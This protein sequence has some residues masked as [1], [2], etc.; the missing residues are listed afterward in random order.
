MI[1]QVVASKP[2]GHG[3]VD[4]DVGTTLIRSFTSLLLRASSAMFPPTR[5]ENHIATS[6]RSDRS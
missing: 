4:Y 2:D 3:D 1:E 6:R 5:K